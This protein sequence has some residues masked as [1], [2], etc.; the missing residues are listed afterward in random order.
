LV[1]V[2][3]TVWDTKYRVNVA[4]PASDARMKTSTSATTAYP[5]CGAECPAIIQTGA[6]RVRHEP[7][8]A[9]PSQVREK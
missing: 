3:P 1:R 8:G 4:G 7:P 2:A 5:R 9:R 6:E